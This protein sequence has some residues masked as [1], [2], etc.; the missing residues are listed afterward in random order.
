MFILR[1]AVSMAMASGKI[2]NRGSEQKKEKKNVK[3]REWFELPE[4]ERR[5]GGREKDKDYCLWS[6]G[7][8]VTVVMETWDQGDVHRCSSSSV[9]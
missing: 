3:K 2:V 9:L 1:R 8:R 4:N 5:S 7:C 6:D